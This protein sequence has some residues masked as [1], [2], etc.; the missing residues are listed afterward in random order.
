MACTAL[1]IFYSPLTRA[2]GAQINP[3]V[4]ITF[5][6]LGKMKKWDAFYYIVFQFVGGTAAVYGMAAIMGEM[7]VGPPVNFAA[8]VPGKGGKWQAL[9]T[10]FVISFAMMSMIL[11]TS[12]H[13]RWKKYT[14]IIA[15]AF[16]CLFVIIA[17]PISGFGMNPARS[18]SSALPSGLW[19]AFWIYLFIPIAGMLAAAEVQ[20]LFKSGLLKLNI[21]SH[22]PDAG[23][24]LRRQTIAKT[25]N[26]KRYEENH[27][28][29]TNRHSG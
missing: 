10:E 18:F 25:E 14:R 23:R 15:G 1:F 28:V 9:Y 24:W 6:R 12:S 13:R 2:S 5:V 21:N 8:T 17:G 19:T 4:T 7:L 16:V 11:F 29:H 26:K 3:A 20:L 27:Q 22:Q